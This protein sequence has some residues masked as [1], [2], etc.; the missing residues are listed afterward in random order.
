VNQRVRVQHGLVIDGMLNADT[1]G[2]GLYIAPEPLGACY[3]PSGVRNDAPG[4][5]SGN[6]MLED[7]GPTHA[8]I[9]H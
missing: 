1:Q 2:N 9:G 7:T 5:A 6:L 4:H 8:C 3:H